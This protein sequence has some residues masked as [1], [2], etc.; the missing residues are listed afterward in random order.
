MLGR[1]R[2]PLREIGS[3]PEPRTSFANERTFLAWIRTSLAMVVA[4]LAIIQLLPEFSVPFGRRIIGLPLI[5]LGFL[6]AV[7]SHRRWERNERALRL[8]EGIP[9]SELPGIIAY[10]VSA[11]AIIAAVLAGLVERG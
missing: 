6:M 11:V 4:G 1:K 7:G 9:H 3:D 8:R 10:G 2:V 5:V